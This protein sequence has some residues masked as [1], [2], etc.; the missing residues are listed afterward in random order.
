VG[1]VAMSLSTI[2]VAADAQLLR[3]LKLLREAL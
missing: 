3:S 2:M 1:A